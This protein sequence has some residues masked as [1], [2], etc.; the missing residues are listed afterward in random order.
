MTWLRRHADVAI[1][2]VVFF[3]AVATNPV[4]DAA[5]VLFA[6][7]TCAALV[8]RRRY[9]LAAFL[10][11]ALFAEA[12]LVVQYSRPGS[13]ILA[14]PLIALYTVAEAASRRRALIIGVGAL[15]A[16]ACLHI[17]AKPSSLLGGDNLALAALGG[18]AVAA[19]DGARSRREYLAEVQTK[20]EAEAARR[21]TDERLRIARD[22]HDAVGHQL[23]LINVQASVAAHVLDER[24][25]SAKEALGHVRQASKTALGELRDTIGLLRQ[26]GDQLPIDPMPGLSG[27]DELLDTFRGS[28][29]VIEPVVQEVAGRI[30]APADLTA[31]R[32]IQEALTNVCKHAGPSHVRIRV[33]HTD[34]ELSVVVDNSRP[35][36]GTSLSAAPGGHG[37]IG[38]R[39]RVAALGG[40]LSA[41]PRPDGGYRVTATLPLST[42]R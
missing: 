19:G 39:E 3:V 17:W 9:P 6:A 16:F 12:Y 27:L 25:G 14:A 33:R 11:S 5:T 2:L 41:G 23:A 28:G 15:L 34:N 37:L 38:M 13:L 10:A 36:P 4:R 21:V 30:P 22:L 18:L 42:P 26:P 31:Y 7:A 1:A 29:L 8:V 40:D 20:A 32:V 24:P 35:S